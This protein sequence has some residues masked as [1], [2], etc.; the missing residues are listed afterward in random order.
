MKA[1]LFL[2]SLMLLIS[3]AGCNAESEDSNANYG[4]DG[5]WNLTHVAGGIDGRN[6]V[7]DPGVIIWTFDENTGM[8]T[9]ANT[10][11]NVLSVFQSGSYPFSIENNG[12]QKSITI[13]G[14]H[15][16]SFV[17]FQDQIFINQQVA[18]GILLELTKVTFEHF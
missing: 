4:L 11:E 16:G 8:V 18:D 17:L 2:C 13:D 7:F 3:I 1:T 15:F 5:H 12:N 10:S 9:I 14:M 6:L